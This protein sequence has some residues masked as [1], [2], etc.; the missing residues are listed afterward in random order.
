MGKYLPKI[1]KTVILNLGL[2]IDEF[3]AQTNIK[4]QDIEQ[5]F[6]NN[7]D[8]DIANLTKFINFCDENHQKKYTFDYLITDNEGKLTD[9][10]F[11]CD[12]FEIGKNGPN[13]LLFL[14]R[15][16]EIYIRLLK[17]FNLDSQFQKP[18]LYVFNKDH[19]GLLLKDPYVRD[20]NGDPIGIKQ[21]LGKDYFLDFEIIYKDIN[22]MNSNFSISDLSLEVT[23]E[24][25]IFEITLEKVLMIF[26]QDN[27]NLLNALK[28]GKLIVSRANFI[29]AFLAAKE[30][31]SSSTKIRNYRFEHFLNS[32]LGNNFDKGSV[33]DINLKILFDFGVTSYEFYEYWIM[34]AKETDPSLKNLNRALLY[35]ISFFEIPNISADTFLTDNQK[36][37]VELG[38]MNKISTFNFL[39][40]NYKLINLLLNAGAYIPLSGESPM[41]INFLKTEQ[42]KEIIK[43]NL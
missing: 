8:W 30:K 1:V 6:S 35:L 12:R 7:K 22:L 33:F 36:W 39:N 40:K 21:N 25:V 16:K 23:Y 28:N 17:E 20:N 42:L 43:K 4:K 5:L 2:T 15:V 34:K 38:F 3:C 37:L 29:D 14:K 27:L 31:L 11:D 41:K 9:K 18:E 13:R 26:R 19:F 24:N 10:D 32:Y